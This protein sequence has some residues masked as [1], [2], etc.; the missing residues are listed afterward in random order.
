MDY[1][2]DFTAASNLIV[3]KVTPNLMAAKEV[4][5]P[6]LKMNYTMAVLTQTLS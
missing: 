6:P 2:N 5:R 3:L 1:S 4:V